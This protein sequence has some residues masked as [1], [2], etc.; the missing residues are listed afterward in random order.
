MA[1]KPEDRYASP[2]EVAEAVAEFADGEELAEVVAALPP[3]NVCVASENT[4]VHGPG[5]NHSSTTRIGARPC[6]GRIAPPP[7]FAQPL[8][9]PTEVPP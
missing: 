9:E 8:D 5:E 7:A 1:K 4:G 2:A 3:H 6:L